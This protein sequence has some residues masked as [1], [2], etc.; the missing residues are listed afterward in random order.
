M[1]VTMGYTFGGMKGYGVILETRY[2]LTYLPI[3]YFDLRYKCHLNIC[4]TTT[5]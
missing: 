5:R 3:S 2:V 1:S 4:I